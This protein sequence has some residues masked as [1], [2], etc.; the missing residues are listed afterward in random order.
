MYVSL[1]EGLL[2][3]MEVV[4][5]YTYNDIIWWKGKGKG[6]YVITRI[7]A[8]HIYETVTIQAV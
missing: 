8:Q 7:K 2:Y 1:E 3:F 4:A 5:K 6:L